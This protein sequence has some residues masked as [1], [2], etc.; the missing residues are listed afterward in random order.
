MTLDEQLPVYIVEGANWVIEIQLDE[1]DAQMT[2]DEQKI[3]AA[4][5]A[6]EIVNGVAEPNPTFEKTDDSEGAYIGAVLFVYPKEEGPNKE[7]EKGMIP[8]FLAL[9]NGGFYMDSMDAEKA[10][11]QELKA[12]QEARA[13]DT[14]K[15]INN[16]E[17][18]QKELKNVE[19]P[20]KPNKKKISKRRK[21]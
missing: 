20:K 13:K 1:D 5:K 12:E 21:E 16:F 6:C 8:S 18:L 3:E 7:V 17:K 10:L 19:T 14:E 2:V 15:D 9:A 11:M 4:T